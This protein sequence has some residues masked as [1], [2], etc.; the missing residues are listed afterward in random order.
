MT[1]VISGS[2]P[3]FFFL[4]PSRQLHNYNIKSGRNGSCGQSGE[5]RVSRIDESV[6]RV[7]RETFHGFHKLSGREINVVSRIR[8][9]NIRAEGFLN[10]ERYRQRTGESFAK[11]AV[12]ASLF[13]CPAFGS[14]SN[15]LTV[16]SHFF[17]SFARETGH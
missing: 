7:P 13:L 2:F 3:R 15:G 4:S 11:K 8:R 5:H 1:A 9:A 14:S 12:A 10:P 16:S 6:S 17:D